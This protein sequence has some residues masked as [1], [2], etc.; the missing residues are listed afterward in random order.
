M[1]GPAADEVAEM[2]RDSIRMYRY[3]RQLSLLHKAEAMTAAPASRRK[4]CR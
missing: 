3:Q 1:L 2:L 4:Q